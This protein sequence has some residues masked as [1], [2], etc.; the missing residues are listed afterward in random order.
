VT[1]FIHPETAV[2]QAAMFKQLA[3][4]GACLGLHMHPWKYSMWRH[5]GKRYMAHY[6]DLPAGEQRELLRE[7][8]AVWQEAIGIRPLYF[9]P[10]T[11]SANDA[12]FRI[13]AECGFRGGSCSAPGRVLREFRAIWTGTEPD[14]HR[15]NAEFRQA[16]GDL[17]FAEMPLSADFSA[18]LTGRVERRMH[19][20]LR[21]DT[22]WQAQYGVSY[23]TIAR[24]I[25][26]QVIERKPAVPVINLMTHNHYDYRDERAGATQRLRVV[27]EVLEEACAAAG[28]RA[29]G[30]TLAD[31]ADAVLAAPPVKEAFVSEGTV[32]EMTV[33][34]A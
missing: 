19:A 7:A 31:V 12:I 27:F 20:D 25:V 15:A 4:K 8:S 26:S 33:N 2:A 3:D 32:F 17:D 18:L 28:V 16:H 29:V 1:Y 21:P 30:A 34:A 9:R 24:N 22:D 13:L 6:G 5:A 14:P 23:K 11:F 10:G